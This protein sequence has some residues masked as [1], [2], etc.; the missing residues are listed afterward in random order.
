MI[1]YGSNHINRF[2]DIGIYSFFLCLIRW[3]LRLLSGIQW[4]AAISMQ[5]LREHRCCQVVKIVVHGGP[6]IRVWWTL[7]M[8]RIVAAPIWTCWIIPLYTA[9]HPKFGDCCF[10]IPHRIFPQYP[11]WRQDQFP[12][13]RKRQE[14]SNIVAFRMRPGSLFERPDLCNT[15][16]CCHW[17]EKCLLLQIVVFF[18]QILGHFPQ[19]VVYFLQIVVYFPETVDYFPQMVCAGII[20]VLFRS[21]FFVSDFARWL[22]L[23]CFLA[24]TTLIRRVGKYFFPHWVQDMHEQIKADA[25]Q[26]MCPYISL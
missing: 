5:H 24:F 1:E 23:W 12:V 4:L 21:S 8:L 18:P 26:S 11:I 14:F 9:P 2:P 17:A 16:L 19:I 10:R 20:I 22:H 7:W 13:L 6:P 3:F 25:V 15:T